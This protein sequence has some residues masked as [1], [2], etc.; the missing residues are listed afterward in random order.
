MLE[1][2]ELKRIAENRWII[3]EKSKGKKVLEL[4]CINH[5]IQG[6]KGQRKLGIWLFDYLH[7]YASKATGIDIDVKGVKYLTKQGLD[8]QVGDAQKFNLGEKFDV[9]IAS[10]LIDHLLNIEGFFFKL[11]T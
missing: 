9:I 6:I 3:V 8:V 1:L 5:T 4:G 11:S 7:K 2:K 10:K